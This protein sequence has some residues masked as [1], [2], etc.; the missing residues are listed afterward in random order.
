MTPWTVTHQGSSVLEIPQA[1]ILE[2][3]AISLSKASWWDGLLPP[4]WWVEL[5]LFPQVG[6]AM[7]GDVL[8]CVCEL[9]TTLGNLSSDGVGCVLVLLVL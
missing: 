3:V 9:T 5:S 8:G 4:L 1:R 2:W 6:E 7:S